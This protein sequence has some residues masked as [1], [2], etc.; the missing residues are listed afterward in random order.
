MKLNNITQTQLLEVL[1]NSVD[2]M[3]SRIKEKPESIN[4]TR[5]NCLNIPINQPDGKYSILYKDSESLSDGEFNLINVR[6]KMLNNIKKMNSLSIGVSGVENNEMIVY[7]DKE[8]SNS[9]KDNKN[10][11][12]KNNGNVDY[13]SFGDFESIIARHKTDT[14]DII[15]LQKK[16]DSITQKLN[17]SEAALQQ[18]GVEQ[19]ESEKKYQDELDKKQKLIEMIKEAIDTQNNI[20]VQEKLRYESVIE[21]SEEKLKRNNEQIA[22]IQMETNEKN[23]QTA[24][25]IE[26]NAKLQSMY[27]SISI[28]GEDKVDFSLTE[29]DQTPTKK[30]A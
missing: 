17:E 24:A 22:K 9:Q 19:T 28:N 6:D 25:L 5:N 18:S 13:S 3:P 29:E 23:K 8:K 11:K 30:I 16:V 12:L 10:D 2:A 4:T 21:S 7:D 1:E 26:E 14:S 20:V 15:D 27:N